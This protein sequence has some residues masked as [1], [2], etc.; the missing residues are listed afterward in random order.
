MATCEGK[1]RMDVMG[2][3]IQHFRHMSRL[4]CMEALAI[5]IQIT[6]LRRHENNLLECKLSKNSLATVVT[7]AIH[8]DL[9]AAGGSGWRWSIRRGGGG[10]GR[11]RRRRG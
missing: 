6:I 7:L 8:C 11:G 5:L 3:F 10:G 4:M 9:A 1:N 2:M